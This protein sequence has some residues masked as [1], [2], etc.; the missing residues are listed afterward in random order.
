MAIT[1]VS[2]EN[3]TRV[4]YLVYKQVTETLALVKQASETLNDTGDV[5][6]DSLDNASSHLK[7]VIDMLDH[8]LR[9]NA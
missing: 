2:N 6:S 9:A 1:T 7:C 5:E 4:D 8:Y 3:K